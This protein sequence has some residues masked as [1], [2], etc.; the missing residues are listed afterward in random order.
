MSR[1]NLELSVEAF[2]A[3][4]R[5]FT[6]GQADLYE[7]L[8]P[9]VE[10][11]PITAILDGRTYRGHEGVRRWIEDLKRDWE[12]F[13][14]RA[15]ELHDLGDR[16]LALGHWNAR[17]RSSG[18]ELRDQSAAWLA[19]WCDGRIVRMQTFTDQAKARE[20]AGLAG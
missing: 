15:G 6:Q 19:E 8:D 1:S 20:A 18:V 7:Y 2:A 5:A 10:W 14:T 17:G 12:V 16:I 3:F 13:E 11:I 4:N 9:D